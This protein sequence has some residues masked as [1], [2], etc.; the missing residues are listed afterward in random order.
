M[1]PLPTDDYDVS[2][3]LLSVPTLPHLRSPSYLGSAISSATSNT[4]SRLLILVFSP[5][6]DDLDHGGL[7]PTH[8]W[9]DVQR[10][11]TYIYVEA[12][13]VAQAKGNILMAIDVVLLP[14]EPERLLPE[15]HSVDSVNWKAV[16]VLDVG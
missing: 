6:F 10:L 1:T 5:L 16:Y 2:V 15:I 4:L 9:K 8:S 13:R 11:L 7:A 3:L 14:T 12:T